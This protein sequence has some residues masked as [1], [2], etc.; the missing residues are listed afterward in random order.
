LFSPSEKEQYKVTF[1]VKFW[2]TRG[3][4]PT[5]GNKTRRYGGNTSCVAIRADKTLLICDAGTGIRE[6]GEHINGQGSD[7]VKGHIFFSHTHWDHIQGFPFFSPAYRNENTFHIW[8]S[9]LQGGRIHSLLSGQ[10]H[11]DYFPVSFGDLKASIIAETMNDSY[12]II[13]GV[14]VTSIKQVHPGICT[15]FRFEKNGRSV[16]YAT[17]HELDLSIS[18]K[19]ETLADLEVMRILPEEFVAFCSGASLLI[20]DGQFTE[21]EYPKKIGWGHSRATTA[22]DLAVQA[23]VEQ[24]AVFHHDP[25]QSDRDVEDKIANARARAAK[26]CPDLIVFGAREGVELKI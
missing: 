19:K 12:S 15:A 17:D 2:G 10:M 20:C 24:L 22:V 23:N 3:S 14:K 8:A 7:P 16:V 13:D 25:M 5:P 1:F 11:S 26:M 4:I 21:S 6:L 9:A 18:N